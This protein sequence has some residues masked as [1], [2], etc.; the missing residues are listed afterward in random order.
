MTAALT[1]SCFRN[2]HGMDHTTRLIAYFEHP[3]PV[4]PKSEPDAGD[5]IT[6]R[7]QRFLA[8]G[9]ITRK[10]PASMI[11]DRA[12]AVPEIEIVT[13]HANPPHSNP[14]QLSWETRGFPVT[15]VRRPLSGKRRTLQQVP[16]RQRE[17][18]GLGKG[19]L[20]KKALGVPACRI[21]RS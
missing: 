14:T 3:A 11:H 6:G 2:W 18:L 19:I 4:M 16:K 9:T 8:S 13:G 10:V 21:P 20:A 17:T 7:Q 5:R 15:G 1:G 12:G